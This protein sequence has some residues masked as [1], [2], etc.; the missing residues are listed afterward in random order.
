MTKKKF[1]C[2]KI[3]CFSDKINFNPDKNF[4]KKYTIVAE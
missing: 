4:V 3:Y 2:D 1:V